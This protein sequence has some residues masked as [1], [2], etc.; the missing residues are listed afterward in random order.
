MKKDIIYRCTYQTIRA[1]LI[2]FWLYVGM[3]KLWIRDAFALS[4]TQQPLIGTL[5]PF[6]SWLMPIMEITLAALLFMPRKRLEYLGWILS[7]LLIIIFSAYIALGITGLLEDAPCMCSSFLTNIHRVTH[8]WING[9]LFIL[10]LA[11]FW[12]STKPSNNSALHTE[13]KRHK[14]KIRLFFLFLLV[15]VIG[16]VQVLHLG[17]LKNAIQYPM[18]GAPFPS[19][20]ADGL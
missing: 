17:S 12:L 13:Y 19:T 16:E 10:S 9:F 6:L 3:D 14:L 8:L 2:L 18:R 15:I 4:L 20:F 7:L 1:T 5:A 11:G